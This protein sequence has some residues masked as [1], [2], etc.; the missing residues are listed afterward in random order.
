MKTI[1]SFL[2][3]VITLA[4]LNGSVVAAQS[5][6]RGRSVSPRA[7]VLNLYNQHKRQSPFFQTRSRV[8]LDRYFTRELAD[9]IWSDARASQGEVGALNGDPLYNAQDMQIRNFS[10]RER[11]VG[12][13]AAEV[14]ATFEN[15]NKKHEIN[16]RMVPAGM[17]WKVADIAYDDGTT[18][19]GILR[20]DRAAAQ[21]GVAVKIYLVALGDNG[22]TGKKIGCDDSLVPVTRTV[23][24][25][26]APLRAAIAQLLATPQHP[27]EN[28][29]LE[30]FWKGRDL[31]LMSVS[32]NNKTATIH[33]S[34]EVFVAG[35]CDIPRIE[36]QIEETAKQFPTVRR[37]RVF[38]AGRTLR[39]A[40]R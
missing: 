6:R 17:R 14:W 4:A 9:L 5:S 30:N 21:Q 35:I 2:L 18:L 11:S 32:I 34:G 38:L 1:K 16:F 31:K 23:N 20:A 15:F 8:Q 40:I 39:D 3:V 22:K 7:V 28:P 10:L 33:I 25:T 24:R 29:K 26:V 13:G 36:S 12:T 19:A 37:V 27:A